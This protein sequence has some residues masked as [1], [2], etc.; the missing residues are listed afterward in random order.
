M[1]RSD[2]ILGLLVVANLIGVVAWFKIPP[3]SPMIA[4]VGLPGPRANTGRSCS[5][6]YRLDAWIRTP[7]RAVTCVGPRGIHDLRELQEVTYDQLTRR[8]E[9]VRVSLRPADSAT[10]S[11]RQDSIVQAIQR[12]GGQEIV[13]ALPHRSLTNIKAE[14]HWRF[15][16]F[17]VRLVAYHYED[18]HPLSPEWLLQID[19]F[20]PRAPGCMLAAPA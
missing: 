17:D 1:R 15:E 7:S 8:V 4:A 12:R 20:A 18:P 16:G 10:W 13:C 5:A 14:R 19:A 2:V 11:I 3:S 9:H 6:M